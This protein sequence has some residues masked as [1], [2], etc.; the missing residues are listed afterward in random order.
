MQLTRYVYPALASWSN[1][2]DDSEHRPRRQLRHRNSGL[3][4]QPSFPNRQNRSQSRILEPAPSATSLAVLGLARS[5]PR[6]GIGVVASQMD[7]LVYRLLPRRPGHGYAGG[8]LAVYDTGGLSASGTS[9]CRQDC[10]D[11]CDW[12]VGCDIVRVVVWSSSKALGINL[13][14]ACIP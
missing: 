9:G 4:S 3:I 7:R 10:L 1:A 14:I 12:A 13:D 5:N 8:D 6:R 11:T 2:I